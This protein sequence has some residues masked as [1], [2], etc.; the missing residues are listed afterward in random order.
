MH[1]EWGNGIAGGGVGMR[2]D[3]GWFGMGEILMFRLLE[4]AGRPKE[5]TR[6][7]LVPLRTKGTP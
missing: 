7:C 5:S 1:G 3:M 6:L 4:F 2:G